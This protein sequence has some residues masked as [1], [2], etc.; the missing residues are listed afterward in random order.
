[1]K[2]VLI[3]P[4]DWGLGHA[5]RCI[6]I[7]QEFI[8]KGWEVHIACEEKPQYLLKCEF[9]TLTYHTLN[10]VQI[11]YPKKVS[12]ALGLAFQ[13]P[14]ILMGIRRERREVN[15]LHSQFHFDLII[16]DNR[17]G[18][19]VPHTNNIYM[20]HQVT[21]AIPVPW[22]FLE[23]LGR[24]AHSLFYRHH[25]YLLIPD[26]PPNHAFRMAGGLSISPLNKALYIGCLSRFQST[27]QELDKKF[28]LFVSLSGPEPSRTQ[29]ETKICSLLVNSNLQVC[30]VRGLPLSNETDMHVTGCD[31]Q[32]YSHLNTA[33][34]Q[35]KILQSKLIVSRSGYSSIM[36]YFKLDSKALLIPTPGQ[37]EQEALATDLRKQ[38]LFHAVQQ[39]HLCLGDIEKALQE[40]SLKRHNLDSDYFNQFWKKIYE[41]FG[42]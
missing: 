16:S 3:T 19:Y 15:S 38:G 10:G 1:M 7:I 11:I 12:M 13:I 24:W 31:I 20:T 18:V 4:L 35:S 29:L 40:E 17:F 22:K 33:D 39:D 8:N 21:I 6:P 36:D 28:D 42:D 2:K 25:D 34:F 41:S 37:T 23:P 9:P 27:S 26:Y 5:T 30:L 14:Q 32:V